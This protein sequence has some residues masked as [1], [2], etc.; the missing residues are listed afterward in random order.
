MERP[1]KTERKM[2]IL[3]T[4]DWH[5]GKKT[6]NKSRI[7][8]QRAVLD[9][10]IEIILQEKIDVTVVAGDVF[11][12]AVPSSEAEELFFEYAYKIG[13]EN[14]LVV[15]SGNHDDASRLCAPSALARACNVITYGNDFT[16]FAK[17]G[18]C[19]NE[20]GVIYTKNSQTLALALLPY[21]SDS[22]LSL[23]ED[24]IY[25]DKV[26]K[27]IEQKCSIFNTGCIN[28]FASH[29]FMVGGITSANDERELGSAKLLPIEVLPENCFTLLGHVHK[30]MTVSKTK[31]AHYS[32]SII[33]YSFDD[34][35]EKRVIVLDSD[36]V[37]YS[38]K[39]IP[40]SGYRKCERVQA[41][42]LEK[43]EQILDSNPNLIEI[44][45]TGE[46]TLLPS[47][48][49]R[50]RRRENFAKIVVER[51]GSVQRKVRKEMSAKE[52][53][54]AFY[55]KKKGVKPRENITEMF[56]DYM[57]ESQRGE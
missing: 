10:I 36:G 22:Y 44:R 57:A 7:R 54:E 1:Q 37:K 27:L 8:E 34:N 4:S 9:R 51:K 32:G 23:K 17:D 43:I 49:A 41:D 48:F 13:K 45:Y 55:E 15:L 50:L 31:N 16:P 38:I 20:N 24:E 33:P 11:D 42:S 52:I 14:L 56:V 21:P 5:L 46:E 47:D 29:L 3:C 40:L 25:S 2:R 35:S 18:L 6:E 53:F 30:P 26:A 28:M 19:V 39:S 12:T